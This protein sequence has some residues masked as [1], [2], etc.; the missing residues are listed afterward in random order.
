[1]LI[2]TLTKLA[3][4]GKEDTQCKIE[5]QVV[6]RPFLL[7]LLPSSLR[8]IRRPK[9]KVAIAISVSGI[10]RINQFCYSFAYMQRLL[11]RISVGRGK[12]KQSSIIY[13]NFLVLLTLAMRS[14]WQKGLSLQSRGCRK[15]RAPTY[16]FSLFSTSLI[17]NFTQASGN[18]NISKFNKV[19]QK[20][21]YFSF[22]SL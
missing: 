3:I 11:R 18:C 19:S 5:M 10:M 21:Q 20:S 14:S 4:K 13:I 8:N 7:F 9:S 1:M 12:K 15:T 2:E 6:M 17:P 22:H 16:M